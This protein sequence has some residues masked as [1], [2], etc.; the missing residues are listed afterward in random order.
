MYCWAT[1]EDIHFMDEFEE[2]SYQW[3]VL[4]RI[5][6]SQIELMIAAMCILHEAHKHEVL[7]EHQLHFRSL[8]WLHNSIVGCQRPIFPCWALP[9]S[10]PV[11]NE[12]LHWATFDCGQRMSAAIAVRRICHN[13]V[14]QSRKLLVPIWIEWTKFCLLAT[15]KTRY[16]KLFQGWVYW[17]TCLVFDDVCCCRFDIT[18]IWLISSGRLR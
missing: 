17:I 4:N 18:L 6:H 16:S 15:S 13:W 10:K 9:V 2:L 1:D 7:L 5:I 11:I 12:G 14:F 3:N 8:H